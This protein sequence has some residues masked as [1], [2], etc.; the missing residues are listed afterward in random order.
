MGSILDNCQFFTSNVHLLKSHNKGEV[1]VGGVASSAII[2]WFCFSCPVW[3]RI[4]GRGQTTSN[5]R[6][7]RS[8]RISVVA[9]QDWR[10]F[11][12][13]FTL[14]DLCYIRLISAPSVMRAQSM[15][16][17]NSSM[18]KP[19]IFKAFLLFTSGWGLL[20]YTYQYWPFLSHTHTHTHTHT[21]EYTFF[22]KYDQATVDIATWYQSVRK[23]WTTSET[24]RLSAQYHAIIY[25][26]IFTNT[27]NVPFHVFETSLHMHKLNLFQKICMRLLLLSQT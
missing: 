13:R 22:K 24:D 16:G 10:R 11:S 17:L 3:W 26:T 18:T 15:L 14:H 12:S 5:Y 27:V 4:T 6:S 7:V 9:G 1:S 25:N 19:Q 2:P 20:V 23:T 21:Q 8:C